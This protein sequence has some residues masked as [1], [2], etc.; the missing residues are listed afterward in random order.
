MKEINSRAELDL[1]EIHASFFQGYDKQ[2][3]LFLWSAIAKIVSLPAGKIR[4][5]DNVID[6]YPQSK[7]SSVS[8]ENDDL[9]DLVLKES[10]G[11]QIPG[12]IKTVAALMKFLLEAV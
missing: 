10:N 4:P 5:Q 6:L 2:R 8:V 9:A 12:D 1:G 3:F 7:W 11:R